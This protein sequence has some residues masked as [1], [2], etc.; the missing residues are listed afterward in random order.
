MKKLKRN[1]SVP[2]KFDRRRTIA[3]ILF[4]LQACAYFGAIVEKTLST[5]FSNP[6]QIIIFNI[7]GLAGLIVL[8]YS[9]PPEEE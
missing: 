1:S 8:F 4:V 7:L 2:T 5:V 6:I 9:F 3:Y